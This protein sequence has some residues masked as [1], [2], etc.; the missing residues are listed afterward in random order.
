MYLDPTYDGA[1]TKPLVPMQSAFAS[2]HPFLRQRVGAPRVCAIADVTRLEDVLA[3]VRRALETDL[4]PF[5]HEDFTRPRLLARV[6][7]IIQARRA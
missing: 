1:G 4:E 2:Q 7:A 5:V 6:A 3:C